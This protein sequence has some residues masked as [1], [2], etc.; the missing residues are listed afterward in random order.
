MEELANNILIF[1]QNSGVFGVVLSCFILSIESIVPIIPLLVFIC[2]NFIILGPVFG[3]ILS[4]IFTVLGSLLSYYIFR[5]KLSQK[6]IDY[7]KHSEHSKHMKAMK[8]C[9]VVA[10]VKKSN[11]KSLNTT[12]T[13]NAIA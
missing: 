10:G 13:E 11:P 5:K 4:W 1:I 2:I 3:F 8:Y 7:T 12:I 6:F 9:A